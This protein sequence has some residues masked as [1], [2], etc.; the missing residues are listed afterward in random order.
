MRLRRL[1][2]LSIIFP[3]KNESLSIIVAVQICVKLKMILED[4]F[5]RVEF[6]T[7]AAKS[8]VDL[9]TACAVVVPNYH[10]LQDLILIISMK[11]LFVFAMSKN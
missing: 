7:S 3:E 6:H 8:A 10:Q 9:I 5:C 1:L 2:Y 4:L 11:A